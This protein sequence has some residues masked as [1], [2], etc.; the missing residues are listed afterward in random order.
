[1]EGIVTV[2]ISR[3]IEGIMSFPFP[4][5]WKEMC[6]TQNVCVIDFLMKSLVNMYGDDEQW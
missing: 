4:E 3:N 5:R 6:P 1:M 2:Y